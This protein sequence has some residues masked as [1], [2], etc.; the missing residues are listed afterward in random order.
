MERPDFLLHERDLPKQR[1]FY[2]KK[3]P[4]EVFAKECQPD[5]QLFIISDVAVVPAV[6]LPAR[7]G[8]IL[9][10]QVDAENVCPLPFIVDTGAPRL[11]QFPLN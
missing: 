1:P 7:I 4:V 6:I 2:L 8:M 9:A 5:K 10:L 11:T 3:T